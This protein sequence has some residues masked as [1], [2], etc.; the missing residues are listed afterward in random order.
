MLPFGNVLYNKMRWHFIYS[1]E[2]CCTGIKRVFLTKNSLAHL[3]GLLD[4][5]VGGTGKTVVEETLTHYQHLSAL[6]YC[7]SIKL[8]LL[9]SASGV[10]V[11]LLFLHLFEKVKHKIHLPSTSQQR[12]KISFIQSIY[13]STY[14]S[15]Y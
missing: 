9:R 13:L 14:L 10:R 4:R 7:V 5:C 2:N 15:I 12:P 6:K 3:C 11:S 1:E 8:L